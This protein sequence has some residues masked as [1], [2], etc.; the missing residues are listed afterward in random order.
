MQ[1]VETDLLDQLGI[2]T[3]LQLMEFGMRQMFQTAIPS[4]LEGREIITMLGQIYRT[5]K[6]VSLETLKKRLL[7]PQEEQ[8]TLEKLLEI[9]A[10]Q[11]PLRLEG[12]MTWTS[13]LTFLL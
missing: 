13:W 6:N 7:I 8:S 10:I 12:Q 2:M 3:F 4:T 1:V 9:P 11:S 5:M